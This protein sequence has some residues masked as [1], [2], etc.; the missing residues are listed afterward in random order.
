MKV[1]KRVYREMKR[2]AALLQPD[3]AKVLR[4]VRERLTPPAVVAAVAK[5][6]EVGHVIVT[7]AKE[8]A[9]VRSAT[10]A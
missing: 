5:E 9:K 3:Q 2:R 1:C 8:V 6:E 7:E 10:I 4:A